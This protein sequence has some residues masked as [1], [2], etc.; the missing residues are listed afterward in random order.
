MARD[1]KH[2]ILSNL[3]KEKKFKPRGGGSSKRPSNV[4]SRAAHA[5]ALLQALD[6]LPTI[7]QNPGLYLDVQ[8]RPGEVMVG[9]GLDAS[10]LELLNIKQVQPGSA[11]TPHA[12]VFASRDG[13][14]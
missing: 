5:Q 12:T 8:G 6:A 7:Q 3:G 1:Q 10:G 9:S 2:F 4:P 11:E 14:I 13:L